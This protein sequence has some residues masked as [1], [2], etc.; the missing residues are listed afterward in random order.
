MENIVD[1]TTE[2]VHSKRLQFYRAGLDGSLVDPE[3]ISAAEHLEAS[4]QIIE[5]LCEIRRSGNSFSV[6]V[7]WE[8]L[9]DTIDHTWEP[10]QQIQE[11]VP[12]MLLEFLKT[13]TKDS[14]RSKAL[15]QLQL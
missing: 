5:K 13:G 2:T 10:I 1:K 11:D 14:L 12:D 3:I 6:R 15:Q 8:G 7:M 9:P 4:Y